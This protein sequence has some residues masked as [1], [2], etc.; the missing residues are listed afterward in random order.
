MAKIEAVQEKNGEEASQDVLLKF[1]LSINPFFK[2]YSTPRLFGILV[3]IIMFVGVLS[4]FLVNMSCQEVTETSVKYEAVSGSFVNQK[5]FI[6]AFKTDPADLPADSVRETKMCT[7]YVHGYRTVDYG[8][9]E[10]QATDDCIMPPENILADAEFPDAFFFCEPDEIPGTLGDILSPTAK[11]YFEAEWDTNYPG[12]KCGPYAQG[13]YEWLNPGACALW[14]H[15]KTYSY[16]GQSKSSSYPLSWPVYAD[17]PSADVMPIYM[18]GY[19]TSETTTSQVC[20]KGTEAFGAAIGYVNY[21]EMLA[22]LIIAGFL[23]CIGVAKPVHKDASVGALLK[24]A[25]IA[26][27][28]EELEKQKHEKE[29]EEKA[30]LLSKK[31]TEE[32]NAMEM[33]AQKGAQSL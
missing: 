13:G 32:D 5:A 18:H 25:G 30:R 26:A 15:S 8:S 11:E 33:V 7:F 9:Y 20:G 6:D 29:R 31:D 4:I 1:A 2:Y 19:I 24:G 27:M 14:D 17:W 23:V 12:W 22:T 21:F 28:A 3:S 16:C 10:D